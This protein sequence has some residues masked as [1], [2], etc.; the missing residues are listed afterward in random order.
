MPPRR[1]W[2]R[3]LPRT[4]TPPA[5][6]APTPSAG[7]PSPARKPSGRKLGR[8]RW[9]NGRVPPPLSGRHVCCHRPGRVWPCGPRCAA[10]C[11][12][13]WHGN[14][15]PGPASTRQSDNSRFRP[16][17]S[18]WLRTTALP[19]PAVLAS[20]LSPSPSRETDSDVD[21]CGLCPTTAPSPSARILTTSSHAES[22]FPTSRSSAAS[23]HHR[24]NISSVQ[25]TTSAAVSRTSQPT[26]PWSSCVTAAASRSHK[27]P[28]SRCG[29]ARLRK[30]RS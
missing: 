5:A 21:A 13:N 30:H 23:R 3:T 12:A 17:E 19:S 22:I 27:Q 18:R 26:P 14:P 9:E 29:K 28:S 1:G 20:S 25:S 4:R 24:T 10:G 6:A 16:H 15:S 2:A 8:L 11:G 7:P